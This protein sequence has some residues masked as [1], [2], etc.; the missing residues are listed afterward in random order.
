MHGVFGPMRIVAEPPGFVARPRRLISE[1]TLADFR[2]GSKEPSVLLFTQLRQAK[3]QAVHFRLERQ[4]CH[5][6]DESTWDHW[7]PPLP[8]RHR[9]ACLPEVPIQLSGSR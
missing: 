1:P 9:D 4:V 5:L 7:S 8:Q 6:S 2:V 3:R